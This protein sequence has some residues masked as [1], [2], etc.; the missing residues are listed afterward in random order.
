MKNKTSQLLLTFFILTSATYAQQS[1]N[2]APEATA[3]E[4]ENTINGSE[5]SFWD[6]P[7]LQEA[8]FDITPTDRKDGI[9]VGE[10]GIDGGN[11]A[12]I[13]TLAKE[14]ADGKHGSFDSMLISHKGKL[15]F[16]SYYLRGRIDLPH[17]LASTTKA[18]TSLVVGRAIQLGYLSMT[19]L[20]KPLVN[21]LKDLNPAKF[22]SG[23]EKITLHQALTMRGGLSVSEDKWEE[24]KEN[25]AALKGQ[26]LVQALLE[27]SAPITEKSQGFS[28][29]NFNPNLVMQV[30]E[31]VVP[32]TAKDFIK[33]E[34]IDKMDI[35]N[36][37]WGIEIDGLP[38]AGWK[39][40]MTSRAMVKLGTLII[41][42][43]KRNG[44][45]LIPEAFIARVT[46]KIVTL[47]DDQVFYSGNNV[48][49]PGYGYFWWKA[50]M[51]TGDRTFSTI[52]AQ[53]GG[54]QYIIVI[55]ALDL[56]VVVTAHASEENTMQ[57]TAQR[58]LPMFIK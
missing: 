8:F 18:Y 20:D 52:S 54:G 24:L 16:E 58:I 22:V 36:Y 51:K 30:I 9:P 47:K 4:I 31:A 42:K 57:M 23:V 43:G 55:E 12:M 5:T 29:G 32:G 49:D 14:I 39:S 13:L 48:S 10:L 34:F 45:Q 44:K 53:G 27:N 46:N 40:S 38:T 50:N 3:V 7:F 26:G 56:I 17:P 28:Y 21:F 2:L 35:T 41:N 25:P 1:D 6:V 37:G 11:K 19:D 33:N 15:L